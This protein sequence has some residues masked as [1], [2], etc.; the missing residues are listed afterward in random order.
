M[1]ECG[2]QGYPNAKVIAN[3]KIARYVNESASLEENSFAY[4]SK[5]RFEIHVSNL[6]F[7]CF[8]LNLC[9]K[10]LLTQRRVP[11]LA[12]LLMA[13]ETVPI[14]AMTRQSPSN[15]ITTTI[16]WEMK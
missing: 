15:A 14:L 16:W 1:T 12:Y 13:N 6:F 7:A 11:T 4:F 2:V 5:K 8:L 10:I 3:V 9:L